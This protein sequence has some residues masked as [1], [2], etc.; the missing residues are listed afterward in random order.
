MQPLKLSRMLGSITTGCTVLKP[1]LHGLLSVSTAGCLHHWVL[2]KAHS[3]GWSRN[4]GSAAV[5][6]GG[7][8]ALH[9]GTFAVL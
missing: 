1:K 7:C 9:G 8:S 4:G 2:L 6:M 3:S 5:Q